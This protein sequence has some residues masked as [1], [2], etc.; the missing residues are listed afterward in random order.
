MQVSGFTSTFL[1]S[2]MMVALMHCERR[3]K[4]EFRHELESAMQNGR[5][6]VWSP[7]GRACWDRK[8]QEHV[9]PKFDNPEFRKELL[10]AGFLRGDPEY[11]DIAVE[12]Y[13]KCV[14]ESRLW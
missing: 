3:T 8:Y 14:D 10:E 1:L 7:I 4:D 12:S 9:L 2:E 13:T 6:Y 5:D 11:L